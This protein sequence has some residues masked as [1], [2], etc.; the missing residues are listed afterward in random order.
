MEKYR[1]REKIYE[2]I[3]EEYYPELKYVTDRPAFWYNFTQRSY[4]DY[5]EALLEITAKRK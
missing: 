1:I 5:D 4:S 2:F 3:P